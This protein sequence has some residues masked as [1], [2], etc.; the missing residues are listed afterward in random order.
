[1][2]SCGKK[3]VTLWNEKQLQNQQSII[4]LLPSLNRR[5]SDPVLF[6]RSDPARSTKCN[7]A[8]RYSSVMHSFK[9]LSLWL[10]GWSLRICSTVMVK[11]AW[12]RLKEKRNAFSTRFPNISCKLGSSSKVR[13]FELYYVKCNWSAHTRTM[14]LPR[15]PFKWSYKTKK[16]QVQVWF[17]IQLQ[18]LKG[19]F[20]QYTHERTISTSRRLK[21][22]LA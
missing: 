18:I 13:I 17:K 6:A 7:F 4:Y 1:M 10:F 21:T 22:S 14:K 19:W 3:G 2:N 15:F 12:E 5:P 8:Q 9:L 20:Q 11:M 16:L